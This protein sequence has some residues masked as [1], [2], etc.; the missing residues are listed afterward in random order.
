[1]ASAFSM[2]SVA[3]VNQWLLPP[4]SKSRPVGLRGEHG[5]RNMQEIG[6]RVSG[7]LSLSASFPEVGADRVAGWSLAAASTFEG[8]R[9]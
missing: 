1:V 2:I 5:L 4:D 7:R 6:L 9:V 8:D 3:A